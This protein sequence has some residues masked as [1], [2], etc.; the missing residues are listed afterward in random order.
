MR[1]LLS[2]DIEIEGITVIAY[3]DM[4]GENSYITSGILKLLTMRK[5]KLSMDKH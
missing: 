3:I 1:E 5:M 4:K 2:I